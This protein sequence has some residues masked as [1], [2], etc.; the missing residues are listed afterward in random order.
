[1]KQIVAFGLV[2]LA[3][4]AFG[5]TPQLMAYR[6]FD[7]ELRETRAF[8]DMGVKLRAFGVCN[9]YSGAGWFYSSYPPVWKGPGEYDWPALDSQVED[10]LKASPDAELMCLVD[11]NSPPWLQRRMHF[12]S[13]DSVSSAACC[14]LWRTQAAEWLKAVI[15][16]CEEKWGSRIRAYGIMAGQTTEWFEYDFT[17]TNHEKNEAWRAWCRAR[18]VD[19]GEAVPNEMEL[20]RAAF[21]GVMYDPATEGL[22]IEYWRFHNGVVAQALVDMARIAKTAAKGK[23]VGSFFGYYNICNK[24]LASQG[25]LA[26]ETVAASPDVDFFSSPATYT[27]RACG[28]GTQT[29][30]VPGTLRRHGKRFLHEIDFWPYDKLVWFKRPRYW[31]TAEDTVAGNTRDA[32]YALVNHASFWWF[33]QKGG[34]YTAPGLHERIARLAKVHARFRDDESPLLADVMF[35]ADPDSA[36]GMIDETIAAF[37]KRRPVCPD[38]FAPFLGCGERLSLDCGSAGAVVDTCSFADLPHLDLSR[39][40]LFALPASWTITPEKLAILRK[41]VLTGGR[42]VLWTYAP[43][44]SDGRTLDAARVAEFA[45]VPFRTRGVPVTKRDGWTAVYA[46]DY[47]E[48]TVAKLRGILSA[49]GCHFWTDDPLPTMA[50]E[51]MLA[52]HCAK[53]GRR[54]VRLPRRYAEVVDLLTGRTVAKD[55][56]SFADDFASPDTKLYELKGEEGK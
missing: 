50:N 54:T 13:F 51:R 28:F 16:H 31:H 12:D 24:N 19:G 25:H 2:A 21:E 56:V 55:A 17:R 52:I 47:R 10:L 53:G 42:T 39:V 8:A 36:C 35:V 41:H 22:K 7:P 46:Y 37:G 48:L 32:A 29:M 38:G 15:G 9:T 1:M 23:T 34:F 45:G 6:S 33:D 44:V 5:R 11:L 40:K 20:A 3:A 43:G 18:G 49:A 14:G 30:A 27:D 4:S 26:Y